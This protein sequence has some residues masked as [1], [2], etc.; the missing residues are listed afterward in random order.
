MLMEV[1]R[2]IRVNVPTLSE[3]IKAAR[4]ADGRS[5]QVLATAAGIS[6][7]YWYQIENNQRRWISEETLRGIE[8]ALNIDF[9]VTF[10]D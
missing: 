8:S 3:R 2:Q 5:A 7:G 9:G 6:T 4:E 10:D 1:V